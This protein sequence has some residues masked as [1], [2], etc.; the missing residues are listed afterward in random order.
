MYKV[1]FPILIQ[2]K[3]HA[4]LVKVRI[5]PIKVQ[6][7]ILVN[8]ILKNLEGFKHGSGIYGRRN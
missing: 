1:K 5:Y 8:S 2:L 4:T 6:F 3:L 7:F